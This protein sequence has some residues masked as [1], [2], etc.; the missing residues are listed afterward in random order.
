SGV[1]AVSANALC[2]FFTVRQRSILSSQYVKALLIMRSCLFFMV[3]PLFPC[4][5]I[6]MKGVGANLGMNAHM[7]LVVNLTL[8]SLI[9]AWFNCCLFYRHQV[10]LPVSHP[11]KLQPRGINSVYLVM[12]TVMI[13]NPI[14]FIFTTK[15]DEK[16][17]RPATA[18]SPMAWLLDVPSYKIYT[19]ENTPLLMTFHFPLTMV[20][21]ALCTLTT[22]VLTSHAAEFMNSR[23]LSALN[24][25]R[26]C[27]L[28]I[29]SSILYLS[30]RDFILD[31][32]RIRKRQTMV[33]PQASMNAFTV[34]PRLDDSLLAVSANLLFTFFTFRQRSALSSE[35]IKVLLFLKVSG[36]CDR[37]NSTSPDSSLRLRHSLLPLFHGI[38][39]FPVQGNLHEGSG[40]ETRNDCT[41]IISYQPHSSLH[42]R[43]VV[44]L[45]PVPP[46]SSNYAVQP[47]N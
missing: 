1:L 19:H 10:I 35:Y 45:L 20:T 7:S 6:F 39:S 41:H 26:L 8:L 32:L 5:G 38:P 47:S 17:Q 24:F 46:A 27:I 33:V 9:A 18:E 29:I 25:L 13:I 40:S 34:T 3:S 31:V 16:E 28:K 36:A 4:K 37:F 42:D 14:S 15:D 11:L 23:F 12:N 44:Q 21:L 22:T 2:T 43:C 30:S